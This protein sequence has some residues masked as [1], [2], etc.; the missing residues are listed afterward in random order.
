MKTIPLTKGFSTLVSD[1]DYGRLRKHK[2]QYCK[3]YAIRSV[4]TRKA[5]RYVLM[6][7]EITD[8]PPGLD[9]DHRNRNRLD[10]QRRN[11]RICTRS[12]NL[13]NTAQTWRPLNASGYRGVTRNNKWG[14]GARIVDKHLGTFKDKRTAAF[15]YDFWADF[16]FGKDAIL[17]FKKAA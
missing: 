4:G 11:L 10:N 5:R 3:G 7:R 17:N 6:H 8:C 14:W 15:M 1:R 13:K 9:V 16:L 2:W 12:I